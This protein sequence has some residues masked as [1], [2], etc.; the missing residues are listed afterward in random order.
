MFD[1]IEI[2]LIITLLIISLLQSKAVKDIKASGKLYT[3]KQQIYFS[4]QQPKQKKGYQ[5]NKNRNQRNY[6]HDS[7]NSDDSVYD[8]DYLPFS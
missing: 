3:V 6:D 4:E 5:K 8:E 2:I 1:L 7:V